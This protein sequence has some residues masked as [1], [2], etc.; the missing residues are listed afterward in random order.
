MPP[1]SSWKA[2]ERRVARELGGR[3]RGPDYG[4][5]AGGKSDVVHE[6]WSPE[7]KLLSRPS[8]SDCL[9]AAKQ[10]G[11]NAEPGL[12]PL[13]FVKRKNSPDESIL[14]IQTLKQFREWRL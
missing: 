11:R 5:A 1:D 10:A 12:E 7:C 8:F 6:H 2:L 4:G 13:A 9:E 14:V 3:R